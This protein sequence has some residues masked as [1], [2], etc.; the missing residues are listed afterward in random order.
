MRLWSFGTY[1]LPEHGGQDVIPIRYRSS[2]V[3]LQNGAFDYDGQ[4]AVLQT[5]NIARNATIITD[6]QNS[7]RS[8]TKQANKGRLILRGIER[9]NTQYLTFAKMVRIGLSPN[10]ERYNC[11]EALDVVFEQDYPFWLNSAD[12]ETFL[13]DGEQLDDYSWNLDG[14]HVDTITIAATGAGETNDVSTIN[15]AGSAPAYRGYF[16]LSFQNDYDVNW[17]KIINHTNGLQLYYEL[18]ISGSGGIGDWSFNWL[19]KTLL[20]NTSDLDRSGLIFPNNQPDWFRLEVGDNEIEVVLNHNN[21]TDMT[22]GV[23]WSRHYTY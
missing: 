9:D 23:Y 8:L 10:A 5:T 15:N 6:I 1:T 12:V 2:L 17:V 3:E 21:D 7:F 18:P 4:K 13:E 11:E 16:V 19:S 22:L 20:T 14:G